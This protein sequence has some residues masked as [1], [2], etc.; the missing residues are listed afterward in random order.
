MPDDSRAHAA[1]GTGAIKLPVQLR[2]IIDEAVG[3][4]FCD[5]HHQLTARVVEA[6]LRARRR[7]NAY[8]ETVCMRM[9][10]S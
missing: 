6:E 2:Q 5:E 8:I 7:L 1:K 9:D 4:E 3:P 10:C